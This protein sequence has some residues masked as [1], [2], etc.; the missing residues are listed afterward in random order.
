MRA[1]TKAGFE[2]PQEPDGRSRQGRAHR[3]LFRR[4]GR[5]RVRLDRRAAGGEISIHGSFGDHDTGWAKN[6]KGMY[7]ILHGAEDKSYPADQVNGVVDELRDAKVPFQLEIYSGTGHGFSV[8]KNKDEE[9]AN[10]NRSPTASYAQRA[11][12]HLN[13]A[14]RSARRSRQVG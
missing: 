1:R 3:L 6:V 4:R 12:R 14:V 10:A 8:P 5:R 13:A 9:R 11:L 7:L 2:R